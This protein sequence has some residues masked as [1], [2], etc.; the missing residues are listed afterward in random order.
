MV[1]RDS[2]S[3]QTVRMSTNSHGRSS[4]E[5]RYLLSGFSSSPSSIFC[6]RVPSGIRHRCTAARHSTLSAKYP[7]LAVSIP[8]RSASYAFSIGELRTGSASP[9]RSRSG[10]EPCAAFFG[11]SH[12]RTYR[13]PFLLKR[14][15]QSEHRRRLTSWLELVFE[16]VRVI[17]TGFGFFS[18]GSRT[19]SQ[20][21]AGRK[22]LLRNF[23]SRRHS[24]HRLT[25]IS[26]L[27]HGP[28]RGER[29]LVARAAAQVQRAAD[30]VLAVTTH[31]PEMCRSCSAQSRARLSPPV[32][33]RRLTADIFSELC[34]ITFHSARAER[35]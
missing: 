8:A 20:R 31:T 30:Y 18:P 10:K 34:V 28:P 22:W 19:P 23:R 5:I 12:E 1:C 13:S 15:S 2:R 17:T 14:S 35:T 3:E 26:V 7:N 21:A 32:T 6:V 9:S 4:S 25:L 16:I 27:Y 33:L 29:S 11:L 24:L